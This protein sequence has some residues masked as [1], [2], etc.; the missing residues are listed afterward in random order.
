MGKTEI[1][2]ST[3]CHLP[4]G[5]IMY[6]NILIV[7]MERSEEEQ[8]PFEAH[9]ETLLSFSTVFGSLKMSKSLAKLM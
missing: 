6:N 5:I 8:S 4:E 7:I 1:H 3:D 2:E 9:I